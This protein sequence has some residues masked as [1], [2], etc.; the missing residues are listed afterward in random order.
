[1]TPVAPRIV[2]DV[3]CV[4]RINHESDFVWQARYSVTL[5][6]HLCCSAQCK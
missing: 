1:M 4:M 2:N 3:S 5:E 6:K